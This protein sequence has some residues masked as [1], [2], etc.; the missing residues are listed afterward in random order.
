MN[1]FS[2]AFGNL[3]INTQASPQAKPNGVAPGQSILGQVSNTARKEGSRIVIA[4]LEKMGKTSLAADA[5]RAMLVQLEVGGAT[6]KIPKTPFLTSYGQVMQFMD[7]VKA[8]CMAGTFQA[9]TLIFDTATA[10]ERYI[11][12]ATIMA[13]NKGK[14]SMETAHG[15]YGKAYAYANGLFDD[16]LK[17]ADELAIN[18]GINIIFTCHVFASTQLDP[19]HGEFDQWDLLLHS[20]KNNKTYGKREMI[21]QWADLVGFLYE[22]MFITKGD[23]EQLARGLSKNVGRVLGVSR[24]PGYVA[25]NRFGLTGECP[26][27]DPTRNAYG[28]AWNT[29]AQG[30]YNASGIDLFNRD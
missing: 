12:D 6:V 2:G 27:P 10:L 25:G 9:Q 28:V 18:A 29:L 17:A 16:F 30:I 26:I 14:Q 19:Q 20:P 13:D 22:P 1:D 8:S 4:G 7:E 11:H 3:G 23:G 24:T 21:T 15:G 5:P